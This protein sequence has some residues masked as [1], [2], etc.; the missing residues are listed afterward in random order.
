[1]VNDIGDTLLAAS[2]RFLIIA[3]IMSDL[4]EPSYLGSS[5]VLSKTPERL[6]STCNEPVQ[7][8]EQCSRDITEKKN[9]M[10]VI[11]F[12]FILKMW[13]QRRNYKK[14]E[15]SKSILTIITTIMVKVVSKH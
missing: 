12:G 4:A 8:Q 5:T 15:L 10:L 13:L 9:T 11:L 6:N 3:L 1:M 2:A 14:N 7:T